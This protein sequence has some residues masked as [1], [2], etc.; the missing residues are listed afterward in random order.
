MIA[1]T[2]T[3]HDLDKALAYARCMEFTEYCRAQDDQGRLVQMRHAET[4]LTP[5]AQAAMTSYSEPLAI[6]AVVTDEDPDTTAVL[7][8]IARLIAV[9][10][11]VQLRILPDDS[12][13]SPLAILLPDVDTASA[14]EEWDLP[15]FFVFDDEW[16]FQAQWGPRP[17]QAERNLEAWL[18][19]YPEYDALAEDESESA[20]RR[21]AELTTALTYE[22][23]LWYNSSLAAAC[24]EEFCD[25]LAALSPPDEPNDGED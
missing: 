6:L 15:Q 7:P 4:R 20:Q 2:R 22:M 19:R 5:G 25:L 17:A 21:F 3:A 8:I 11:R 1:E 16:E 14:L 18:S 12:D 13:L 23:R 9:A 24:Q 10:P